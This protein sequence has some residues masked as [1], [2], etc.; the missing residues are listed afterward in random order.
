MNVIDV[1]KIVDRLGGWPS[2]SV[3]YVDHNGHELIEMSTGTDL[4][5]VSREDYSEWVNEGPIYTEYQDGGWIKN[6]NNICP[7]PVGTVVDIKF[8]DDE[9]HHN[10]PAGLRSIK[11]RSALYWNATTIS[12]FAICYWRPSIVD[13]SA[14]DTI[15]AATTHLK[16]KQQELQAAIDRLI[17]IKTKEY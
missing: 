2:D 3:K 4:H 14:D 9:I 13:D 12:P 8:G 11:E 16:L 1:L 5:S 6:I 15:E 10:L 17:A 7:V